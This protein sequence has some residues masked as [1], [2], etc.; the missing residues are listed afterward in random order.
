MMRRV[1]FWRMLILKISM[2]EDAR[3]LGFGSF[4][5]HSGYV[6]IL[7]M[8]V[9]DADIDGLGMN[10]DLLEMGFV[11]RRK[12]RPRVRISS[13]MGGFVQKAKGVAAGGWP[14]R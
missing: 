7:F 9:D 1:V 13:M 12:I 3:E 11:E 2:L 8:V 14:I 10:M 4:D 6:G 5:T